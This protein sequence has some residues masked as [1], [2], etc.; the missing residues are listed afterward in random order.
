[1][2]LPP[3]DVW[4]TPAF[5]SGDQDTDAQ[6]DELRAAGCTVIYPEHASGASR[7]RPELVRLMAQIQPGDILTIVRLDRLARSVSHLLE[8]VEQLQ[9]RGIYIRSL[10]DPIDTSTKPGMFSLQVLAAVAQLER[11]LISE[12]TKAVSKRPAPEADNPATR[13]SGKKKRARS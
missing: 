1:M 2:R 12:R 3:R 10:R 8:T 7:A 11:A 4:D 13:A 9:D 5:S 6:E